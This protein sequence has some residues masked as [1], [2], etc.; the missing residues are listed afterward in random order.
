VEIELQLHF[1]LL[2]HVLRNF[3]FG[4][5]ELILIL[6]LELLDYSCIFHFDVIDLS[7]IGLLDIRSIAVL[8]G[9]EETLV[10]SVDFSEFCAELLVFHLLELYLLGGDG[11]LLIVLGF[12]EF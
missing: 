2:L 1:I 10:G 7:L 8:G 9:I 6:A 4:D 12:E 11:F 5:G 3:P